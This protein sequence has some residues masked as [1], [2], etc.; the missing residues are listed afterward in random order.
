MTAVL[1]Q[2]VP[3]RQRQDS[4]LASE[5]TLRAGPRPTW[6]AECDGNGAS[7]YLE[8]HMGD[9]GVFGWMINPMSPARPPP[10]VNVCCGTEV[11]PPGGPRPLVLFGVKRAAARRCGS[12]TGIGGLAV[13]AGVERSGGC[14][15]TTRGRVSLEGGRALGPPGFWYRCG[16]F[17][18]RV[19]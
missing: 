1:T 17:A 6:L 5:R 19:E 14:L 3:S 15:K 9:T 7:L 8:N 11:S 2:R 13:P 18:R 12:D 4:A 10:C 16:R